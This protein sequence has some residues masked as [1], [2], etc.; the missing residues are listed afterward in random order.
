MGAVCTN[1]ALV[2]ALLRDATSDFARSPAAYPAAAPTP[3]RPP[4]PASWELGKPYLERHL[5]TLG[6]TP[7]EIFASLFRR[8]TA[9]LIEAREH[10]NDAIVEIQDSDGHVLAR[11]DHPTERRSGYP[12]NYP[13]PDV[14]LDR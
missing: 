3:Q 1:L 6:T 2:R 9:W 12:A 4:A 8:G 10:G 11:A 13:Y 5:V 7:A 14:S